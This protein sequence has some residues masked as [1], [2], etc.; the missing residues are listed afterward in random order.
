LADK[1][2]L[3]G[4]FHS[5]KIPVAERLHPDN[6]VSALQSAGRDAALYA[7]ADVIVTNLVPQLASGDVVGILSNGGFDGIYEKLPA[8]LKARFAKQGS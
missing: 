2:I 1:V 5:E 3:A 4:V 8:A 6:V 7:N